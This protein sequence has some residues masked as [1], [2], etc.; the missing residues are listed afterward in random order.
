MK[1][2][3]HIQIPNETAGTIGIDK[4]IQIVH[5]RKGAFSKVDN[6][7]KDEATWTEDAFVQVSHGMDENRRRLRMAVVDSKIVATIFGRRVCDKSRKPVN[8]HFQGATVPASSAERGPQN[9]Q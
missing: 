4:S 9:P 7:I 8:D 5:E 3:K 1:I 2:V 6:F